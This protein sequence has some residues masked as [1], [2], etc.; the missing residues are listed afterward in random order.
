MRR[1]FFGRCA[2]YLGILFIIGI[3]V[4]PLFWMV[5]ISAVDKFRLGSQLIPALKDLSLLNYQYLFSETRFLLWFRNSTRVA[6]IATAI[7]IVVSTFGGYALSRFRFHGRRI[8]AVSLLFS[9]M[10]PAVI[11]LIPLYV[12][13][14][15]LHL[16]NDYRGLA[17]SYLTFA[18][19]F[20]I[21]MLWGYFDSV[22]IELEEAA[23]IDGA[24]RMQA[25]YK[26]ILPLTAPGIG[27]V[28][29]FTFVL[30]WQ[31][32]L[33]ALTLMSS[34]SVTTLP[35]GAARFIGQGGEILWGKMMALGT[36]TTLPVVIFFAFMQRYLVRGLT[37]GAVKG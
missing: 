23:M 25:L 19:P 20:S 12:V 30:C 26:V 2:I 36:M 29:I 7:S 33:A 37:A 11:L 18:L 15:K 9:Q 3:M 14:G 34:E 13:L 31:E 21:W 22:P 32:Y 10:L 1:I 5:L 27:A 6:V 16:T 28:T 8:F 35:V 17:L 24:T 4:F